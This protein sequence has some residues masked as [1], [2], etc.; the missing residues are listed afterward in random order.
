MVVGARRLRGRSDLSSPVGPSRLRGRCKQASGRCKKCKRCE[1]TDGA[2]AISG[3]ATRRTR[4]G[5]RRSHGRGPSQGGLY[6]HWRPNAGWQTEEQFSDG[7]LRLLGLLWVFLD[8]GAPLL[9]E[10]PELSLHTGVV[11]HIPQ[12]MAR[13][14]RKG[15]RQIIVSSHSAELLNDE[16]LAAQEV[17]LLKPSPDGT[18]VEVASGNHQV[19]ALLEGG[20]SMAEAVIPRTT[21]PNTNQRGRGDS[22]GLPPDQTRSGTHR[23]RDARRPE[24]VAG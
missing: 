15:G 22:V 3:A 21:P 16:G 13:L 18:T 4:I 24:E 9:L 5:P 1:Q 11:R 12:I 7:T 8:G 17:L 23:S 10:E 14:G 6:K 19:V 20:S 2:S